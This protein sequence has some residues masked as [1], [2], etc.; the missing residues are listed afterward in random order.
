MLL[1]LSIESPKHVFLVSLSSTLVVSP[2]RLDTRVD[3]FLSSSFPSLVS[4]CERQVEYIASLALL[5]PP[6][7]NDLLFGRCS[8]FPSLAVATECGP[9]DLDQLA[10]DW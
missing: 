8:G 1:D 7:S 5:E 3:Y 9:T 4:C 2:S 10:N 6:S